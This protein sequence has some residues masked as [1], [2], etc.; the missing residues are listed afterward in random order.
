MLKKRNQNQVMKKV[1]KLLLLLVFLTIQQTFAQQNDTLRLSHQS[2]LAIVKAYHPLAF[3]YRLQNKMAK[4][5]I[6]KARGNFDPV[7][8]GKTGKKTIDGTN[9]YKESN[10]ELNIPT[11][12]G[13][14]FNGAYNNLNGDRLNTSDTKG[15]L[16]QFGVTIPLAKNLLYDSRRAMLDQAKFALQ[17]TEAEQNMLTNDLLLD[18]ENTYW[19]WVKNYENYLLQSQAIAINKKRM[20]FINKTFNYGERAAI[21]TTEALSQLQSFELQQKDAY[22][23]FVK[24]TQALQ[25]FLWKENQEIYD[26]QQLII[27][28]EKLTNNDAYQSYNALIQE[29]DGQQIKNHNALLY[30][31]Q[32]QN[33]LTSEQRLKRQSFLPKLDFTYNFINKESYKPELFP[34]FQNN[35]QYGLK[36]EIPIFLRQARAD[37]QITKTKIAQNKFDTDLKTRELQT[38]IVSY[39]NEVLNYRSQINVAEQNIGNYKRLLDAEETK[40]ANGESS[41]FLINSRENKLIEAQEKM[42]ELRLKFL[43][44]YNQLKW[45]N[46]NFN[47]NGN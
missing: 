13:V 12:Y 16:Y 41:L 8:E 20:E 25:L 44:G 43:N 4:A 1:S 5:E 39:K 11:W 29:V 18:A 40:Y 32:K 15:G 27:P 3:R 28:S 31:L 19:N 38:K 23:Q 47:E 46:A 21:D 2:F 9:Y 37:Y 26:I 33:I 34:L 7:L 42:L 14:S 17:M 30:Y 35:Y 45:I 10:V 22:L 24:A 6:L 36:L